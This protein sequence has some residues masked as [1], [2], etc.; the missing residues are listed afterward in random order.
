MEP[1]STDWMSSPTAGAQLRCALVTFGW[2]ASGSPGCRAAAVE[3]V[4]AADKKS[5]GPRGEAWKKRAAAAQHKLWHYKPH[6]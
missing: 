5:S 6:P 1:S 2:V 4:R 3:D